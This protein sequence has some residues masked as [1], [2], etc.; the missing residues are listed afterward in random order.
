MF[1]IS[2]FEETSAINRFIV[3]PHRSNMPTLYLII[4]LKDGSIKMRNF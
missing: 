4:N 1:K 2:F 3:F